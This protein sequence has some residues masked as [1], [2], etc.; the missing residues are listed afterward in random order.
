MP[1]QILNPHPELPEELNRRML[2][3]D[4]DVPEVALERF[5]GVDPLEVIHHL[6]KPIDLLHVERQGF[7]DFARGAPAAIR[8]DVRGHSN[9]QPFRTCPEPVGS[10]SS[11]FASGAMP[12]VFLVHVLD[13]ALA[14]VAARQIEIDVGPLAALSRQKPLE[15][16]FHA[17]RIHGSDAEAVAHGAVGGRSSSLHE[18]VLL[19][20]EIDDVP[21]D[22]EIAGEIELLNQIQLAGDLRPCTIVI[23][24]VP[25]PCPGLGDL[26]QERGHRFALRHRVIREPVPEVRHRVLEAIGQLV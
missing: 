21:D 17:H 22:E 24:P 9:S 4:A 8:D 2:M 13:H 15:Q 26:P 7:A 25:L 12:P 11:P 18:D 23:R 5:L 14:T 20:A 6:G 1:R 16:Q 3:I 10:G 19:P